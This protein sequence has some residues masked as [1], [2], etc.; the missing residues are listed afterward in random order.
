MTCAMSP[1]WRITSL[2]KKTGSSTTAPRGTAR[3]RHS[4]M[5]VSSSP[6]K[7]VRRGAL[8]GCGVVG[9]ARAA[10]DA[11]EQEGHRHHV[12]RLVETGNTHAPEAGPA[13]AAAV[14]GAGRA[15]RGQTAARYGRAIEGIRTFCAPG[16]VN[17]IGEYTDLAGGLV[18]PAALELGVTI[19]ARRADT[20][21]LS[22]RERPGEVNIAADGSS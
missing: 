11:A 4:A 17:L 18:L 13:A 5:V 1:C 22:S 7:S 21:R 9:L 3:E 10:V 8:L 19:E 14:C 12:E 15:R 6:K 20:I 16:R 2:T